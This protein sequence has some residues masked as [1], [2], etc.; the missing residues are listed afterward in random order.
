MR[1]KRKRKVRKNGTGKIILLCFII[2]IIGCAITLVSLGLTHDIFSIKNF[3][4]S[5]NS[6]IS[7]EEIIE[8]S[9]SVGQ[10]IFLTKTKQIEKNLSKKDILKTEVSK[11][12][13]NTL[14][15]DLIENKDIAFIKDKNKNKYYV[16]ALGEVS[17]KRIGKEKNLPEIKGVDIKLLKDNGNIFDDRNI[18]LIFN[19]IKNSDLNIKEYNFEKKDKITIKS[20][21][22][23]IIIGDL[24]DLD[25][26]MEIVAKLLGDVSIKSTGFL[27]I[28]ISDIDNPIVVER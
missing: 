4:I 23:N 5:G 9:K 14:V 11:K 8:R 24:K 28:D 19:V 16:N 20:E 15:I 22:I 25:E 3:E 21:E 7:N 2:F 1:K 27:K 17:K 12:L 26:K 10:N 13:P 6:N 18:E